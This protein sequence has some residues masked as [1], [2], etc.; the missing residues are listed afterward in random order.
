MDCA[1]CGTLLPDSAL[2]CPGCGRR[3]TERRPAVAARTRATPL[4]AQ[5]TI[6]REEVQAALAARQEL[7]ERMEPEIIDAFLDRI[8]RAIDTRVEARLRGRQESRPQGTDVGGVW[9]ALGSF[10][11]GIPLTAIAA[12]MA[13]LLGLIVVW[14]GIAA[15]NLAYHQQRKT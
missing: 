13:G 4:P 9:L 1:S 3:L 10:G 14:A 8:E 2:F 6:P 12:N 11:L 5:R 7:G 15:V